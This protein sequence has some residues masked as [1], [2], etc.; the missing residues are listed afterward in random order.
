MI[1]FGPLLETF[2][3]TGFSI[4]SWIDSCGVAHDVSFSLFCVFLSGF[5]L[6]GKAKAIRLPI[7]IISPLCCKLRAL[8]P[9]GFG[10]FKTGAFL[11]P[12]FER[13]PQADRR[14]EYECSTHNL[15]GMAVKKCQRTLGRDNT[16]RGT[17]QTYHRFLQ[18]FGRLE[19]C[20]RSGQT[21]ILR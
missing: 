19:V 11:R 20:K 17:K 3:L 5:E 14:E 1:Q 8:F 6:D 12:L 18:A 16:R 10:K 13:I 9:I 2:Q 21:I 15:T 4:I 7:G